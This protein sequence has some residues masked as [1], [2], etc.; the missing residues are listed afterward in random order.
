MCATVSPLSVTA[1]TFSKTVESVIFADSLRISAPFLLSTA[2]S[3]LSLPVTVTLTG[4]S[5]LPTNTCGT[6]AESTVTSAS[7]RTS[8]TLPEPPML[9]LPMASTNM[10]SPSVTVM[11]T[12][13]STS[14]ETAM[15]STAVLAPL[16]SSEASVST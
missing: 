13:L 3:M 14:P 9:A 1:G 16:I 7:A 4:A 5:A 15:R 10:T 6:V 8:P 2:I 11:S 12:G